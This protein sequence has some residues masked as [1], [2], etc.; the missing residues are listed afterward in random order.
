MAR[1]A[2]GALRGLGIVV[3]AGDPAQLPGELVPFH[4]L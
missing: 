1:T 2:A 4:F 3:D